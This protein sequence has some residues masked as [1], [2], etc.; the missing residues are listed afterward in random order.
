[1]ATVHHSPDVVVTGKFDWLEVT[2][3]ARSW[4]AVH[5]PD[6]PKVLR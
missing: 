5:F 2:A 6:E 3:R 1:V 4:S